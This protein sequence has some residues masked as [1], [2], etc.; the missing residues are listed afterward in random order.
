MQYEIKEVIL[1]MPNALVRNHLD[2]A[3][4]VGIEEVVSLTKSTILQIDPQVNTFIPAQSPTE[5]SRAPSLQDSL[6]MNTF[7]VLLI[8]HTNLLQ[9]DY[10]LI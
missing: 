9:D 10:L 1:L 8:C 2:C 7:P 6:A 4:L 3:D 5:I